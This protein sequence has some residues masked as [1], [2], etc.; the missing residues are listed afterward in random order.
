MVAAFIGVE[1]MTASPQAKQSS[2]PVWEKYYLDA[3]EVVSIFARAHFASRLVVSSSAWEI[4]I[5]S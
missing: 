4:Q 1:A 2:S 5:E 3:L